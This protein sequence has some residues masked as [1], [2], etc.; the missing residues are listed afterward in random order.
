M[1]R[2][3]RIKFSYERGRQI[4]LFLFCLFL[5][6]IIWSVHRLSE[7]YSVFLEYRVNVST[8]I[9]GR[10]ESSLSDN[11]L[12]IKARTSGFYIIQQRLTGSAAIINIKP[13]GKLFKKRIG[14]KDGFYILIQDIRQKV[15]EYFGEALSIEGFNTDTLNFAFALQTSKE[16]PIVPVKVI[17]FSDQYMQSSSLVISPSKVMI[18][19]NRDVIDKIDSVYTN[20]IKLNK[21]R[22]SKSGVVS[23]KP[24]NGVR[25]STNELLYSLNV[26]R[27]VEKVANVKIMIKGASDNSRVSISPANLLVRYRIPYGS[28]FDLSLSKAIFYIDFDDIENSLNNYVKPKVEGLS[29]EVIDMSISPVFVKASIIK[30]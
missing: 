12:I 17:T 18:Y 30:K 6:F 9:P 25:F 13:D 4:L 19:G 1:L 21:I 3:W 20:P 29:S 27:Y 28:R 10:S 8:N 15:N 11:T 24:I 26:V 16:V 22:S 5:A 14:K 2:P 7:N 23:L